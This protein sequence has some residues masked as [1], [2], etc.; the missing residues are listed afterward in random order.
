VNEKRV[1]TVSATNVEGVVMAE[2][3]D[4]ANLSSPS[5]QWVFEVE[6]KD[7]GSA[8]QEVDILT[9][10]RVR[11]R[12]TGAL[13]LSFYTTESCHPLN[14]PQQ[15]PAEQ[16]TE[17]VFELDGRVVTLRYRDGQEAKRNLWYGEQ[18]FAG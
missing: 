11:L 18:M 14:R 1:Q 12:E 17:F 3:R 8:Y 9:R 7:V 16:L 2:V 15:P 13:V 5:E 6:T 4:S 10:Y